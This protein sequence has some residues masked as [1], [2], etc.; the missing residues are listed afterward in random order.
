MNSAPEP[1]TRRQSS[2]HQPRDPLRDRLLQQFSELH[3]RRRWVRRSLWMSAALAP[4]IFGL[5]WSTGPIRDWLVAP[6]AGGPGSRIASPLP[7]TEPA[8]GD[9]T[10][11]ESN[12]AV[13]Q[14]DSLISNPLHQL[15]AGSRERLWDRTAN[16]GRRPTARIHGGRRPA[17]G[18]GRDGWTLGCDPAQKITRGQG[19]QNWGR[20]Q[21]HA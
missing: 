14:A 7:L 2:F 21:S 10:L 9:G 17:C 3:Q 1:T 19:R 20:H 18:I 11:P 15:A 5:V 6:S 16:S 8:T 4:L 13:A 12:G